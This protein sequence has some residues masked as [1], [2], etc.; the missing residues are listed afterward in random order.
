MFIDTN[1]LVKEVKE[2]LLGK[3]PSEITQDRPIAKY[4]IRNHFLYK[5]TIIGQTTASLHRYLTI[6][7]FQKGY[8]WAIYS[9]QA[10]DINGKP[11][12]GS[13]R[14]NTKWKIHKINGKWE[15]VEIFE[16]P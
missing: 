10:Y 6:H 15:I 2:A 5:N 9:N 7:N 16:A 11:F 3:T 1:S 8:I 4:N 14:I 12:S 13:Y